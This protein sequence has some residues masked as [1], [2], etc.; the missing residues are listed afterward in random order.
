MTLRHKTL[1][2]IAATLLGLLLVLSLVLSRIW[3]TGFERVEIQQTYQ[4]VQRVSDAIAN[5]M[6]ELEAMVGDWSPWDETYQFIEDRNA[7]YIAGNLDNS[8]IANFKLNLVVYINQAG[9]IVFAQGFD[10]QKH[11]VTPLPSGLQEHL[12]NHPRLARHAE[13]ESKLSG[14][15]MLPE[16]PFLVASQPIRRSDRSG[17]IRGTLIFGR[18]LDASKFKKLEALTHLSIAAF[19]AQQPLPED[20]RAAQ[21]ALG[22]S[23][24]IYVEPLSRDRIAGY[25]QIRDIYNNPALLI[26]VDSERDVYHKGL[27]S[28]RYLIQVLFSTGLLFGIVTLVLLEKLVLSRLTRLSREVS[29]IRDTE[30][31]SLRL[32]EGG[33]DELSRLIR[34]LNQLLVTLEHSQ[35]A[36]SQSKEELEQRVEQRTIDLRRT[37]ED[38]LAEMAERHQVEL[39]LR[40]SE[41][42][43]RTY[44][45]QLEQA[46]WQLKETQTQLIH[47]EKMSSLGQ[48]VAGVAHE[49]NNPLTFIAGNLTYANSYI[50]DLLGLLERYQQHYCCP[51]AEIQ[52]EANSIDL[53]FLIDDLP[54]LLS[55]M[56]VGVDR[57]Q[58]IVLALRNFSRID[59]ANFKPSD[60]HEGLEST[61]LILQS[62]LRAKSGF[63]GITIIKEYGDLPL[64]ECDAGQINQVFMNILSN[65]IDA[66]EEYQQHFQLHP[67]L[68]ATIWIR[69]QRLNSQ[70]IAIRIADN[71]SGISE[72][73]QRQLFDPFFTT[74]SV[75]KGTGLGLSISYRIITERHGGNLQCISTPGQGAEFII[76]LPIQQE[77][78]N[79]EHN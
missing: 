77:V 47:S 42:Y 78:L 15:L 22:D 65:A 67:E 34:M 31:L 51:A 70:R 73:T 40:S 39:Q 30:D 46:L 3:L 61:L 26:R 57:I 45:Q 35:Q 20:F 64:V 25:T 17:P 16:A 27:R 11:E 79:E 29:N 1:L 24:S 76:E 43:L 7:A 71:G 10:L 68:S 23:S 60:L 56:Q 8:S 59:G 72:T 13:L 28:W 12:T 50:H 19:P 49:I 2:I 62:R 4:N 41:N 53:D 58:E 74:K 63:A 75:G 52:A 32:Q 6:A 54:K 14:I 38:L 9:K 18:C 21:M 69:T 48:L 37:N 5:D 36:L 33:R 55:S 44:A 66:L